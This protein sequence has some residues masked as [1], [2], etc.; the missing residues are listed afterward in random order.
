MSL[1]REKVDN[2]IEKII[3]N[4]KPA[5]LS[6][7]VLVKDLSKKD[8]VVIDCSTDSKISKGL[9]SVSNQLNVKLNINNLYCKYI[10]NTPLVENQKYDIVAELLL[11]KGTTLYANIS[12]L[13][14]FQ[15]SD[16]IKITNKA[17]ISSKLDDSFKNITSSQNITLS[18]ES[19]IKIKSV[20][21]EAFSEV[22]KENTKNISLLVEVIKELAEVIDKNGQQF[23]GD[24]TSDLPTSF[25]NEPN[26]KDND[27]SFN[28]NEDVPFDENDLPSENDENI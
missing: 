4:N 21:K 14:T 27:F 28:E 6:G 26:F 9:T 20:M 12:K 19:I 10:G 16:S 7:C 1:T 18:D 5:S 17:K 25:K 22:L 24:K 13:N 23:L 2:N 15:L 11:S 3:Y 8:W